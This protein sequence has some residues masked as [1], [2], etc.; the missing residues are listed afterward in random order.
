MSPSPDS[1]L[2]SVILGKPLH[3]LSLRDDMVDHIA[4]MD[5]IIP[6][7]PRSKLCSVEDHRNVRG[8]VQE[9]AERCDTCSPGSQ[10]TSASKGTAVPPPQ[11][12]CLSPREAPGLGLAQGRMGGRHQRRERVSDSFLS[13]Y[14]VML[15]LL[16]PSPSPVTPG[17][18]Q[19]EREEIVLRTTSTY[20]PFYDGI[21]C[22]LSQKPQ[23]CHIA[24]LGNQKY[25]R[26]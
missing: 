20:Y 17:R 2:L 7:L 3:I 15:S 24:F 21:L 5:T 22:H 9:T 4:T 14:F 11:M 6:H 10:V 23:N 8:K 18:G 26:R 16:P 19:Q 12:M 1:A 13:M 25:S